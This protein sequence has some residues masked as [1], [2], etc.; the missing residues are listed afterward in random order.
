M[1]K[2]SKSSSLIGKYSFFYNRNI[3]KMLGAVLVRS[4]NKSGWPTWCF[5]VQFF[6]RFDLAKVRILKW[7][8]ENQIGEKEEE[9]EAKPILNMTSSQTWI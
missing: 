9:E 7:K 4:S 8:E 1:F 5:S 6:R 2:T 3:F